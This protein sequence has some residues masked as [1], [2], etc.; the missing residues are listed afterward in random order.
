MCHCHEMPWI[1]RKTDRLTGDYFLHFNQTK[2]RAKSSHLKLNESHQAH[3]L[4]SR[5]ISREC[6]FNLFTSTLVVTFT[7]Q[8]ISVGCWIFCQSVLYN[9]RRPWNMYYRDAFISH[10]GEWV[11]VL[12]VVVSQQDAMTVSHVAAYGGCTSCD[13]QKCHI[14]RSLYRYMK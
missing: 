5:A 6:D 2:C 4:N 9:I 10:S 14:E 13:D 12:V 8:L 7:L 11:S 3:A 1:D